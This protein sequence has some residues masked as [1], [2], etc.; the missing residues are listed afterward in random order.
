MAGHRPPVRER[1]GSTAM[2][3]ISVARP[4]DIPHAT[5]Y[6]DADGRDD[7]PARRDRAAPTPPTTAC[8]SSVE[9]VEDYGLLAH[10]S[11]DDM[12]ERRRRAR[13]RSAPSTSAT[14]PTSSLWKLAKPGEPSWPSPWGDGRPGLAQ[15]VRGDEPRPARRGLRPALRWAWTSSFPHH[16]N[17]RAQAVALGKRFANHW[18][19]HGFVV[20]AEGEKMSKSLGNV[21]NLLDLHRARTTP[22]LPDAAAAGALP[23]PGARS[24]ATTST[25][26]PRRAR[27]PRLVRRRATDVRRRP[28][29]DAGACS[30]RSATRW[31]TTSTRR[32]AMAVLFDDG[33]PGQRRA[34]TPDDPSAGAPL[35]AAV[36][37]SRD[38]VGLELGRRRRGA[39]RR[40]GRG[41]RRSTRRA[42]Q[43]LR[44]RADA[45]RAELQADGWIVETT[46][47]GHLTPSEP[48]GAT[49]PE[50]DRDTNLLPVHGSRRAARSR[51]PRLLDHLDD[52]RPRPDRLRH[53]RPDPRPL[54]PSASGPA[55]LTVGLAVRLVFGWPSSCSRR[56]SAGLSGSH[57]AQAGHP[58]L[59]CSAPAIRQLVTSAGALWSAVR[60]TDH[61]RR[62]GRQRRRSPR[63]AVTDHRSTRPDRKPL[64][65]AARRGVRRR[66]RA[67]TGARWPRGVGRRRTCRSSWLAPLAL[68]NGIV[69]IWR[70]P[71]THTDRVPCGRARSRWPSARACVVS[72]SSLSWPIPPRSPH[73]EATFSLLAS[74]AVFDLGP[75]A[76]SVVFVGI[77]PFLV[78]VQA[79][80]VGRVTRRLRAAERP[81][82]RRCS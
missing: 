6:V 13:G 24:A 65:G 55:R 40:A 35:I 63:R 64:L 33:A 66:L 51:S 56:S 74:H 18:M 27:R 58:H 79:G 12:L 81:A 28:T 49:C 25:R 78:A 9:T 69:A 73:S 71:E 80:L 47:A 68:V 50:R 23:R 32:G 15:R 41:R 17:E 1:C 53:R 77:R 4:T 7:R 67:R 5:E 76:V 52:R 16:E 14:R 20:D 3:A 42:A 57:R 45:I 43:G 22:R 60:R 34:S 59:A 61:R 10:Q 38:A 70:L 62:V 54:T 29:P 46:K 30:T 21:D 37:R 44:A 2:D 36:R 48:D 39:G 19:H 82:G 26:R 11:L 31:T 75:G 72:C 8:T